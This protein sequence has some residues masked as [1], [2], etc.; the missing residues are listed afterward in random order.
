[1]FRTITKW[2]VG[3][4]AEQGSRALLFAGIYINYTIEIIS[5]Y[6]IFLLIFS[7]NSIT[8]LGFLDRIY[9]LLPR[10]SIRNFEKYDF[11]FRSYIKLMIRFQWLLQLS[12]VGFFIY[13][14]DL[15]FWFGI[16]C[17]LYINAAQYANAYVTYQRYRN[18]I[19]IAV[20]TRIKIS[21][22][23]SIITIAC[24]F[25]VPIIAIVALETVSLI[26]LIP[27]F[28]TKMIL[29]LMIRNARGSIKRIKQNK[30]LIILIGITTLAASIDRTLSSVLFPD[31]YFVFLTTV[32]IVLGPIIFII[33]QSL[34]II[35]QRFREEKIITKFVHRQYFYK[36]QKIF[37][38]SSM[39]YVLILVVL[40]SSELFDNSD[41]LA[42][43]NTQV[44]LLTSLMGIHKLQ[45]AVYI[46]SVHNIKNFNSIT[47]YQT[48]VVVCS[49]IWL[50]FAV[51]ATTLDFI[52]ILLI[53]YVLKYGILALFMTIRDIKKSLLWNFIVLISMMTVANIIGDGISIICGGIFATISA[54]LYINELIN[55]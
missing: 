27:L 14:H 50:L 32:N 47:S 15:D 20:L 2:A 24:F 36:Y 13:V 48:V 16:A 53:L 46:S 38:L 5:L 12:L 40:I 42:F 51:K 21:F 41:K 45:E 28:F 39:L 33:N 22:L 30:E 1:M 4:F 9:L 54:C 49:V 55:S 19:D 44:I 34:T 18:R 10:V 52:H 6:S 37:S 29:P 11:I 8:Q 25:N 3:S 23:R 43:T 31:R 26:I 7:L 17:F 35:A